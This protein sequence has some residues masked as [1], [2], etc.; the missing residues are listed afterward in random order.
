MSKAFGMAGVRIGWL[1]TKDPGLRQRLQEFKDYT[2]IN[3]GIIRA[4]LDT[5]DG[6]FEKHDQVFY[7]D[8]PL[9]GTIAF[10][11]ILAG[12]DADTFCEEVLEGAGVLL[13]PASVFEFGTDHCR[14][15]FGRSDLPEAVAALEEYLALSC[16]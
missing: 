11:R 14:V 8:R 9:A 12:L 2:T 6:F 15:G 16:G 5:L 10:P 3:R 1:V 4:N 13:L 7:W